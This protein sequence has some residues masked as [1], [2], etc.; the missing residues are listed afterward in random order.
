MPCRQAWLWVLK[1]LVIAAILW[2]AFLAVLK[3]VQ[4]VSRRACNMSYVLL[5]LSTNWMMLLLFLFGSLVSLTVDPLDLL[6]A[7]SQNMLPLF[8][9]ANLLT[10]A[11]NLSVNSLTVPDNRAVC[12]VC[13]YM[14]LLCWIANVLSVSKLQIRLFPSTSK[15][16]MV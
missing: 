8:L 1:L 4:P 5:S 12:I 10:G 11:V 14:G 15:A 3:G 7:C 13:A 16:K 6:A 9:V 2:T